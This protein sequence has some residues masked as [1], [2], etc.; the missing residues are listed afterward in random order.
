D[1]APEL[2]GQ[3][4]GRNAPPERARAADDGDPN[5]VLLTS[6][7][8][9]TTITPLVHAAEGRDASVL[10][11]IERH[12][13]RAGN[14]RDFKCHEPCSPSHPRSTRKNGAPSSSSTVLTRERSPFWTRP[15]ANPF[16]TFARTRLPASIAFTSRPSNGLVSARRS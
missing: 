14:R 4:R 3:R 12:D 10:A 8:D 11:E 6:A 13:Q 7:R 1:Q 15:S 16:P 5:L 9:R 2:C